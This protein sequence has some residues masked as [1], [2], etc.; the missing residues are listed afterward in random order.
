MLSLCFTVV[1]VAPPNR[2]EAQTYTPT[3]PGATDTPSGS[4]T[5]SPTTR[6]IFGGTASVTPTPVIQNDAC[7]EGSWSP[8]NLDPSWAAVCSHCLPHSTPDAVSGAAA[9]ITIPA[10]TVPMIGLFPTGQTTIIPPTAGTSTPTPTAAPCSSGSLPFWGSASYPSPLDEDN[11][12]GSIFTNGSLRPSNINNDNP[13]G[14]VKNDEVIDGQRVAEV[15]VTWYL[16]YAYWATSLSLQAGVCRNCG[17]TKSGDVYI[18]GDHLGTFVPN[19][20]GQDNTTPV[21]SFSGRWISQVQVVTRQVGGNQYSTA[22]FNWMR[23][24]TS[25]AAQATFTPPAPSATPSP[26]PS[27][28]VPFSSGLF[29]LP[30]QNCSVPVYANH[31]PAVD[32]GIGITG[33]TQCYTLFGGLQIDAVNVLGITTPEIS[34]PQ[35]EVCLQFFT[36]RLVLVGVVID[37]LGILAAALVAFFFRWLVFN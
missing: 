34:I 18:N 29:S 12:P 4:P 14:Y 25:C 21:I 16:P 8:V 28:T 36:I 33:N 11:I 37:V 32:A 3:P 35:F 17:G 5:P 1:F 6:Y 19:G 20:I 9:T 10:R 30:P 22:V 26:S 23:L 27:S 2:A 31:A 13:R 7:P 24:Y 15:V